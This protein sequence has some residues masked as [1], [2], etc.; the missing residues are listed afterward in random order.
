MGES[1]PEAASTELDRRQLAAVKRLLEPGEEILAAAHVFSV[2]FNCYIESSSRSPLAFWMP[3][4]HHHWVAVTDSFLRIG[5]FS[6]CEVPESRYRDS[7]RL[8]NWWKI[9]SYRRRYLTMPSTPGD[10][11]TRHIAVTLAS[12]SNV[13]YDN[14]GTDAYICDGSNVWE[15]R[16]VLDANGYES[17][18]KV[19]IDGSWASPMPLLPLHR[20]SYRAEGHDVEL[21]SFDE[22]LDQVGKKLR[23]MI[24]STKAK[25]ASAKPKRRTARTE[26]ATDVP[27]VHKSIDVDALSKLVELHRGG[28]LTDDEFQLAKKRLLQ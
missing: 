27:E 4:V 13:H 18:G 17:Q 23:S 7:R 21:F 1:L 19:S 11:I 22:A 28:A 9:I 25:P 24:R 6:R 12:I 26:T 8:W 2:E 3:R 20:L 14:A 5:D 10:E 15:W 16:W